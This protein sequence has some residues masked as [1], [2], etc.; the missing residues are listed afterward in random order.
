VRASNPWKELPE[1]PEYVLP[2]DAPHIRRFNEAASLGHMY[3]LS[4]LPEPY[5]GRPDAPVILLALNPGRGGDDA[6]THA[7]SDFQ[8]SARRSLSHTLTPNP[9]LHLH[10]DES[11]PGG[12]WWRRIAGAL[13]REAG[14]A[15][16]GHGL[17]CVQFVAYHSES[18]G[19]PRLRLPSQQYSFDL[20][21]GALE[22]GAE[23]V[24]MRSRKLWDAAIPE[25]SRYKRLHVLRNPRNPS[26]SPGNLS[27]FATIA[28]RVCGGT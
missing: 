6:V 8:A 7:R 22:R 16:V 23:V 5:F 19:S 12:R 4:L 18:F 27:S 3:D 2:E 9:Y 28:N 11:T 1:H 21:R 20:V 14:L 17:F 13:I 25:L 26:L 10:Q 15:K 24:V